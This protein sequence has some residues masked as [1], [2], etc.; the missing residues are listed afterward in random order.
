MAAPSSVNSIWRA[1]PALA[2]VW[3]T[4]AMKEAWACLW[5]RSSLP[6]IQ[7]VMASMGS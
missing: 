7:Q 4:P 3:P 1:I 5:A 2:S 6:S